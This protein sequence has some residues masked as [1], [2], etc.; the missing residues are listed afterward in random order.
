MRIVF[1]LVC[2]ENCFEYR[3]SLQFEMQLYFRYVLKCQMK[4]RS[5]SYIEGF[6]NCCMYFQ[7]FYLSQDYHFRMALVHIRLGKKKLCQN[8][9]VKAESKLMLIYNQKK[10]KINSKLKSGNDKYQLHIRIATIYRRLVTPVL[11]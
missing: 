9:T 5:H 10:K 1:Y 11:S 4:T 8:R 7:G 2:N 6:T 3:S